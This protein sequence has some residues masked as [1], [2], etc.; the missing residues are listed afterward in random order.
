[1]ITIDNNIKR[2][3]QLLKADINLLTTLKSNGKRID[4]S[5]LI[6]T[7]KQLRYCRKLINDSIYANIGKLI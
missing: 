7:Y 4:N 6:E 5:K 1:M 2:R 3:L